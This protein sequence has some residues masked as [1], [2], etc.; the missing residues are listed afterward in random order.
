M[1][2]AFIGTPVELAGPIALKPAWAETVAWKKWLLWGVLGLGVL[3][4]GW[5]AIRLVRQMGQGAD[6]KSS[7]ATEK[8]G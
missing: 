5:M 6:D 4:L 7:A 8:S 3:L 1:K 2:P